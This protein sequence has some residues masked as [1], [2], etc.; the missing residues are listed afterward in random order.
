MTTVYFVRH[1]EADNSVRDGRIRPLT[2]KGTRDT[3]FVMQFLKDKSIDAMVSSPFK[4]AIDT[5]APFA[6]SVG[7]EIELVEDFRER[8]S[9]S[10]WIRDEDFYP[11]MQRQW[12]DYSYSLSDGESLGT[13]QKRNIAALNDAITQHADK[14]ILIGTHGTA[15]S[16]IV[17]FYE[18]T[19]G[20]DDFMAM[21]NIMPWIVKMEFD[22]TACRSIEK[23]DLFAL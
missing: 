13:V 20:F 21:V 15:L 12:A 22:G 19:Y 16:T 4:R 6:E 1:C 8:K 18:P 14:R 7:L 2:E 10:D 5:I 23:I 11:F 17:N 3:A 9:D